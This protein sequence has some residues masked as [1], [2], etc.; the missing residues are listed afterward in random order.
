MTTYTLFTPGPQAPFQFNATLDG[1]QYLVIITWNIFG[2]R[3][4]VNIY[5]LYG[6]LVLAIAMA[7]S[8]PDYNIN[9]VQGYFTTST[10]VY[11]VATNSFEVSP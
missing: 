11:R 8:P 5:D 1:Q 10:F 9:L 2:Q 6:N 3:W 4:Y 7:G